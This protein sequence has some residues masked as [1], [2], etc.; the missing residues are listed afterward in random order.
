MNTE[1][2]QRCDWCGNDP[3]YV[4][5]HDH[6]WGVPVHDERRHFEFLL[7]ESAQAGLSWLTILRKRENFRKAF[8][9]FDPEKIAR[10]N[11][12]KME[13]LLSDPGIIR[14]KMKIRSAINNAARFL[15][16]QNEFGSF[17]NY[18]WKFV[19]GK[20]IVN[21]FHRI[22]EIPVTSDVSDRISAD[23]RKRGFTFVGPTIMYA[24][25]QAIG[26]VNDHLVSCF[27]HHELC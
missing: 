7:L 18:I 26:M 1:Q 13:K 25:L 15:D 10:Y 20:P 22:N 23:L 24:H 27:R 17:D 8:D 4:D 9:Q 2:P 12:Q 11:K 16:V 3:L 21:H 6:E 19:D 14:N 5:Y